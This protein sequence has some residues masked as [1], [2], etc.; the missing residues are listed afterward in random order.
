MKKAVLFFL[1]ICSLVSTRV[2]AQN[3]LEIRD[4]SNNIVNNTTI[5]VKSSDINMDIMPID[6]R[7]KNTTDQ[8]LSLLVTRIMNNEVPLTSNAFC[9]GVLCYA[10]TTDTSTTA[11]ILTP[12]KDTTFLGDYYPSL[13][14]GLTSITYKFFVPGGHSTVAAQVTVNFLVSP[15]GF[16]EDINN[17][18]FSGAFPNP[19]SSSA[20]FE[21]YIP[22]GSLGSIVVRNLLGS[23]VCEVKLE[24][25]QGRSTIYTNE[26]KEGVYFYSLILDNKAVVTKKLVI[27]H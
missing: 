15:M 6:L 17:Y 8:D 19:A 21:Y 20:S 14:S 9:F 3:Q 10:S 23:V 1:F 26:L 27:R 4:L 7:I 13:Q 16:G 24:K 2:L 5:N 11:M 25:S 12:G 22:N 18:E